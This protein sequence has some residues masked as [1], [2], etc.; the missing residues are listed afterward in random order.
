MVFSIS[1][2]RFSADPDSAPTGELNGRCRST[3]TGGLVQL[4]QLENKATGTSMCVNKHALMACLGEQKA[5]E[6]HTLL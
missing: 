4:Q 1:R 6:L 5:N 3:D 2:Y